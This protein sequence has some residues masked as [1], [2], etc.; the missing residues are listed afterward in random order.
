MGWGTEFSVNAYLSR[1]IF[2]NKEEVEDA[3]K[4][5]EGQVQTDRELLLMMTMANPK[6][7]V[8]EGEDVLYV[9]RNRVNDTIDDIIS[10]QRELTLL[11]LYLEAIDEGTAKIGDNEDESQEEN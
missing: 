7:L 1:Q 4:E 11:Y 2:K 5:K 3:I 8:E 10:E 6:D 9:T